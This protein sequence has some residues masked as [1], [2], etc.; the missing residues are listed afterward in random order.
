MVSV[1]PA[2]T[3]NPKAAMTMATAKP[4]EATIADTG[5]RKNRLKLE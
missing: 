4:F 1:A 5:V 3:V 2:G